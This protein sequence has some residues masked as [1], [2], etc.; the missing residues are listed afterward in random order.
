MPTHHNIALFEAN[1]AINPILV[2]IHANYDLLTAIHTPHR[3]LRGAVGLM[4]KI[5]VVVV[6][7]LRPSFASVVG[8]YFA[9]AARR[10]QGG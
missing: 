4:G 6:R 2:R 10:R 8:Y 1:I 7:I 9:G 5:I 3:V